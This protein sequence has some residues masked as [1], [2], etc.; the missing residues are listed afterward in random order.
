M[1]KCPLCGSEDVTKLK[2]GSYRCNSCGI[3]F[4]PS[5]ETIID[6]RDLIA[7]D[8]LTE[9][10]INRLGERMKDVAESVAK[11]V[12]SGKIE[13]VF[14]GVRN[15][16]EILSK[17]EEDERVYG[18][19]MDFEGGVNGILFTLIPE[20]D[21]PRVKDI[22][23]ESNTVISL[24]KFGESIAKMFRGR[25]GGDIDVREIDVAYDS[26]PSMMNYLLSEVGSVKNRMFL[27]V[28]LLYNRS[29]KGEILFV[30]Q[31]DSMKTL[32]RLLK[33]DAF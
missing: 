9:E 26:I 13:S 8:Q 19:F 5:E 22:Y 27:N 23:K 21:A 15:I 28:R 12:F 33:R 6:M 14:S 30:P 17:Y 24:Y 4:Y 7:P 1:V 16:E 32:K 20:K 3:V 11:D 18:I 2:T 25:L 10:E 29:P 31:K